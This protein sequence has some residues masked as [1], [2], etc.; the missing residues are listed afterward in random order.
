MKGKKIEDVSDASDINLKDIMHASPIPKFVIDKD[1]NVVYWNPALEKLSNIKANE[2]L[3]TDNHWRVFY[4]EERPCMADFVVD[5]HL[6]DIPKWYDIKNKRSRFI[7]KYQG[8]TKSKTLGDSCEA[9]DFFPHMSM[10]GKWLHF[11]AHAIKNIE[12][13]IIGAVETFEDVSKQVSLREEFMK[14]FEEKELLLREVDHRVE[15]NL[16]TMSSLINFQPCD[17]DN[18]T[19]LKIFK[20]IHNRIKSMAQIHKKL[21]QSKDLTKIDLGDFVQS[22]ILDLF[23]I[24]KVDRNL[25]QLDLDTKNVLLDINTAIP[26]GL[27]LNELV[28][29]SIKHR[30]S[31]SNYEE[32]SDDQFKNPN[33]IKDKISVK[34]ND[35]GEFFLMTVYDNVTSFP[36][37]LDFQNTNTLSTW[38][39]TS[40]ATQLGGTVELDTANGTL[41]KIT[42]KRIEI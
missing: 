6:E 4:S 32:S 20:E 13:E 7:L 36:E 9:I 37:N 28:T 19:T 21:Y 12:G 15:N 3:G 40:L 31:A 30:I 25:I 24:H 23:R 18:E 2:I 14:T 27:I 17:I 39:V 22:L 38:F 33:K 8:K 34:I 16:E 29:T 41:F 1:H 11:T 10:E 5:E 35:N 26:C 42:F